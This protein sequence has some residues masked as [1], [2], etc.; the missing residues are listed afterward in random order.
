[1]AY[2]EDRVLALEMLRA[3]YAKA[4]LPAAGVLHSHRYTA[5]EELQRSFD[6]GRGL[7]EVYGWREPAAP[8]HLL[9]QLRGGARTSSAGLDPGR[10]RR[11]AGARR[12]T[13]VAATTSSASP[14][15]CSAHGPTGLPAGV[16]GRLSLEGRS[17]FA[18][19]ELG[20][21]RCQPRA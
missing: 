20:D 5:I 19:V 4:F 1:M 15:P 2:A 6:E 11:A 10:P 7:L 3:G 18:A 21:S 16:R 9:R 17:S 14:A 8:G 13:A 12:L